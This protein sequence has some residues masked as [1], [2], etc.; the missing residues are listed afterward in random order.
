MDKFVV[1]QK[2]VLEKIFSLEEVVAYANVTG[3]DNPLHIDEE[4]AKGSRFGG[5][6]VHGMFVMGV[7]SKVLGTQLPGNGTIYLEQDIKF[8][9]PVYVNKKVFIEVE[10]TGIEDD[11]YIYLSTMVFDEERRCLVEGNAKVLYEG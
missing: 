2:V 7:I 4:Y 6:I 8:K 3:D 1:G 11:K 10:I 9:R 5:N